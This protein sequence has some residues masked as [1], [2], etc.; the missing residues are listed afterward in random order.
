METRKNG[1][2]NGRAGMT[3]VANHNPFDFLA[4]LNPNQRAAVQHDRTRSR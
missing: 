3:T 2:P 1:I 4:T